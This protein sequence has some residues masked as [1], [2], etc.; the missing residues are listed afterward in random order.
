M[1]TD[2]DISKFITNV[3]IN[4]NREVDEA[5]LAELVENL[6]KARSEPGTA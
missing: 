2:R 5:V 3:T 6:D 1:S 4:T